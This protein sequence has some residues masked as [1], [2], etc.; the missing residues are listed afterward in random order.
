[1]NTAKAVMVSL[2]LAMVVYTITRGLYL[3]S[4]YA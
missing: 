1:V 2:S 3:R 4:L